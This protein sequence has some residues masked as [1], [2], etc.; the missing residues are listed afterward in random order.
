MSMK[1]N[2]CNEE[3]WKGKSQTMDYRENCSLEV[4]NEYC[5]YLKVFFIFAEM[6]RKEKCAMRL[7]L[8]KIEL[9]CHYA[10]REILL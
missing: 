5:P 10:D 4:K 8:D 9:T 6:Q 2:L 7:L 1:G 3:S